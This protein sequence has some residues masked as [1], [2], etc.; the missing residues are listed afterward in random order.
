MENL[1]GKRVKLIQMVED[2]D[3]IPSGSLGTIKHVGGDVINVDWDNGRKLGL[4][5]G[6]DQYEITE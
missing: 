1:I 5:E 6:V 3:P 2:P 4:I